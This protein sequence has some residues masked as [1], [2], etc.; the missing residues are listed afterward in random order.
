VDILLRDGRFWLAVWAVVNAIVLV[1]WPDFPKP[2]WAALEALVA[3]VV[4]SIAGVSARQQ[5]LTRR[6]RGGTAWH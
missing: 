2:I 3:V 6:A 4:G 5:V 1:V